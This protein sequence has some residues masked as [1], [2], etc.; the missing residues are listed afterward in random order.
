MFFNCRGDPDLTFTVAC[1][2]VHQ[3][4]G[5]NTQDLLTDRP[6]LR[7]ITHPLDWPSVLQRIQTSIDK[8]TDFQ[9]SC[10]LVTES[11]E[12]RWVFV[13]GAAVK[14][15]SETVVKGV[16][17]DISLQKQAELALDRINRIVEAVHLVNQSVVKA[18]SVHG[19]LRDS[20]Q[21]LTESNAYILSRIALL[22]KEGE[23][24]RGYKSVSCG[25][26]HSH[27]EE[28]GRIRL[29]R[30]GRRAYNKPVTILGNTDFCR[31][32]KSA[33]EHEHTFIAPLSIG[34]RIYGLMSVATAKG[35]VIDSDEQKLIVE[36]A[37]DIAYGLDHLHKMEEF[38]RKITNGSEETFRQFME[39]SPIG[40]AVIRNDTIIYSNIRTRAILGHLPDSKNVTE[41]ENIH[42]DDWP[43]FISSYTKFIENKTSTMHTA[44]RITGK[45]QIDRLAKYTWVS[46]RINHVRHKGRDEYVASFNDITRMKEMEEHIRIHDRMSTLGRVSSEIAHEI[47][48][49]L[50]IININTNTLL[51]LCSSI[52][53]P[54]I[55]GQLLQKIKKAS[56]NVEK[57]I[58]RILA[59]SKSRKAEFTLANINEPV[60]NAVD[61]CSDI[62]SRKKIDIDLNL[63]DNLPP[64]HIDSDLIQQVV[65]NLLSNSTDALKNHEGDRRIRVTS[66]NEDDCNV[67]RVSDSGPG[68]P[69]DQQKMV[70]DPFYST[71]SE[72][73]GI[74]L[75]LCHRLVG[76]HNGSISVSD[77]EWGGAEFTVAIPLERRT[78]P[79]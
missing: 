32:E 5:F 78:E 53:G 31:R 14:K 38:E 15:D 23:P 41:L 52:E 19:L 16:I 65:I 75:S 63:T 76:Q 39:D 22:G 70:F 21:A 36:I 74:G 10:R 11:K 18:D 56:N 26:G 79:R 28:T 51:D 12:S 58:K 77:S 34:A 64:C 59:M 54:E 1:G 4:T 20:C 55:A 73:T 24:E 46:C 66:T 67:I 50:S 69:S 29:T 7:H 8:N 61:L 48:N 49:P 30:A 60:T 35:I 68:I 9:I 6:S 45:E 25:D 2:Y 3:I 13:A 27:V 62:F 40:I 37:T 71:K 47:R 57:T 42:K 72:G 17:H 44:F 33:P 43:H